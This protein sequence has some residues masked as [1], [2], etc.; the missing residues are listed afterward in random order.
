MK[1]AQAGD[2]TNGPLFVG[3]RMKSWGHRPANVP[4]PGGSRDE[5]LKFALV[6]RRLQKITKTY[7]NQADNR[8]QSQSAKKAAAIIRKAPTTP[9]TDVSIVPRGTISTQRSSAELFHVEQF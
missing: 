3:R 1:I 7:A 8:I 9:V 4:R 5:A 2:P 6:Q